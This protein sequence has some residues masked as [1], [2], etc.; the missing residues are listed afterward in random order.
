MRKLAITFITSTVFAIS[1]FG[2]VYANPGKGNHGQEMKPESQKQSQNFKGNVKESKD[3][4]DIY[5]ER[6]NNERNKQ[7]T[8]SAITTT[9]QAVN[10]KKDYK[11]W[12]KQTTPSAIIT[13]NQAINLLRDRKGALP[14]VI[15]AG[16]LQIPTGAIANGLKASI[17]W[18]KTTDTVI[19]SKNGVTIKFIGDSKVY[20][21]NVEVNI[22]TIKDGK[23]RLVPMNFIEKTLKTRPVTTPA[24]INVTTP[25]GI[26]T[27]PAAINVT[28]PA[29]ISTTN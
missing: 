5:N 25:S 29:G 21:N 8:P 4:K 26:I 18:D 2:V 22:N 28:T 15:K 20:V 7:T 9:P 6:D 11:D 23:G 10:I 13:T 24:A 19:I 3:K 27:T 12:N 1:I 14:S 17:I 16:K